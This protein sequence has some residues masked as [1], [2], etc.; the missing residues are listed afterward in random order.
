MFIIT[1][2]QALEVLEGRGIKVSYPTIALWVRD[3]K[4]DGAKLKKESR[5]DVWYIPKSSVEN[6]K[7][8]EMGRPRKN[9]K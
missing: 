6:F 7:K 1:T 9:N 4:F 3:G 2:K 5:G 8:P